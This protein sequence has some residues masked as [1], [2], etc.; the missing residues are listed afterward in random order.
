MT[1]Q[2]LH[3]K[4]DIAYSQLNSNKNLQVLPEIK[5]MIL[6]QAVLEYVDSI[7]NSIKSKKYIQFENAIKNDNIQ[8]LIVEK[9][10]PI[11]ISNINPT[12][13][14]LQSY[15]DVGTKGVYYGFTF[16]PSD[17]L[18]FGK[19]MIY[20]DGTFC[21]KP[22]PIPT[23]TK[24]TRYYI[25]KLNEFTPN[26]FITYMG[27]N[28]TI[29][30]L[31]GFP[32]LTNYTKDKHY[33][34]LVN[35]IIDKFRNY[36]DNGVGYNFQLI[37]QLEIAYEKL[38]DVY[39]TECIIIKDAIG[40]GIVYSDIQTNHTIQREVCYDDYLNYNIYHISPLYSIDLNHNFYDNTPFE[41]EYDTIAMFNS[42]LIDL[43]TL[44]GWDSSIS[45][46]EEV[47]V[48]NT[49][50]ALN[51]TD[52]HLFPLLYTYHRATVDTIN[53]PH[54]YI[55]KQTDENLYKFIYEIDKTG[56]EDK[57][58]VYEKIILTDLKLDTLGITPCDLQSNVTLLGSIKNYYYNKSIINN[59]PISLKENTIFIK[60]IL[61]KYRPIFLR[62]NYIK[63]P[64]KINYILNQMCELTNYDDI[65]SIAARIM[66]SYVNNQNEYQIKKIENNE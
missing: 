41:M 16:T 55:F 33:F 51:N 12:I 36:I 66:T 8:K 45:G 28:E 27:F 39:C 49:L 24:A 22:E 58:Y 35:W 63:Q 47:S 44:S 48:A 60:N 6:N 62:L 23:T 9:L 40:L 15:I 64:I 38:D 7:V 21:E 52:N 43:K 20:H 18:Y 34:S 65:V 26:S 1:P 25:L 32:Y 14:Q 31:E 13:N 3:I 4:L 59:V 42:A 61:P 17:Y 29:D 5:D 37:N 57:P 11:N 10:L 30:L 56:E 50:D 54:K 46:Y 2:E 19:A 53:R